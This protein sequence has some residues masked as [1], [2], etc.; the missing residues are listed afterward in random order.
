MACRTRADRILSEEEGPMS[1]RQKLAIAVAMAAIVGR[2]QVLRFL[3]N[4]SGTTV[5]T[6]SVRG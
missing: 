5:R 2:R 1:G 3:T 4:V 6:E